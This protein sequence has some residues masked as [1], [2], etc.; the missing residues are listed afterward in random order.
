V[1]AKLDQVPALNCQLRCWEK[2]YNY[3]RPH[4]SLAYL[5]P[6]EFITRWKFNLGE[7]KGALNLLDEYRSWKN[8]TSTCYS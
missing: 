2:T 8:L 3:V 7:T 5:T 4:Q 6:M 1:Q